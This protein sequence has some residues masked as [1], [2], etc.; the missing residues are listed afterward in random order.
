MLSYDIP[1]TRM[2]N[3]HPHFRETMILGIF[4][5]IHN[6]KCSFLSFSTTRVKRIIWNQHISVNAGVAQILIKTISPRETELD[7]NPGLTLARTLTLSTGERSSG[8]FT[9][10]RR[11]DIMIYN[12]A[13]MNSP[14]NLGRDP[15]SRSEIDLIWKIT[16]AWNWHLKNKYAGN[17]SCRK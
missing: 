5:K 3:F 17:R 15:E 1:V 9:S 8:H 16:I 2:I 10:S 4:Y 6:E 7:S 13:F 11:F 14:K 12:F